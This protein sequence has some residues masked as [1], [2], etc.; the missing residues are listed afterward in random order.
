M[1]KKELNNEYKNKLYAYLRLTSKNYKDS[2][3]A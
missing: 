1:I 3:L 2:E